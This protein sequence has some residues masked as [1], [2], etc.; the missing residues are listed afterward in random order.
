MSKLE[1]KN[2]GTIPGGPK[3]MEHRIHESRSVFGGGIT[4]AH[5]QTVG[6]VV[7]VFDEVQPGTTAVSGLST[8]QVEQLANDLQAYLAKAKNEQG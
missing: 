8:E 7:A 3:V 1:F 6:V 4:V 2:I 5:I